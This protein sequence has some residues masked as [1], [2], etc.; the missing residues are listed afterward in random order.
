VFGPAGVIIY[1]SANEQHSSIRLVE[2]YIAGTSQKK[3]IAQAAIQKQG[4]GEDKT[5]QQEYNQFVIAQLS[6][7]TMSASIS[8][9][10]SIKFV[11]DY[12]KNIGDSLFNYLISKNQDP[13]FENR[14]SIAK[15]LDIDNYSGSE[16]QN[17]TILV[18]LII[19][20]ELMPS[21]ENNSIGK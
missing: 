1:V 9:A 5:L 11:D 20:N 13:S 19:S 21:L 17:K 16:E 10:K 6:G 15:S 2:N 3:Y 18:H 12:I 4:D 8:N 7:N 14:K